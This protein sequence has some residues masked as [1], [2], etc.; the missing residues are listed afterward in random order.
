MN[1]HEGNIY[2]N[3]DSAFI[4]L[5]RYFFASFIPILILFTLASNCLNFCVIYGKSTNCYKYAVVYD[6]KTLKSK[7]E[8]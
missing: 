1:K 4:F 5:L 6:L 7:F 8:T 3:F 2:T